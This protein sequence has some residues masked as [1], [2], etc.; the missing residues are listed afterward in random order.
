[1]SST[2]AA[3]FSIFAITATW[4]ADKEFALQQLEA[5]LRA[6]AASQN[7]ELRRT[8]TAAVLGPAPRRSALREHCCFTCSQNSQLLVIPS[9]S[10]RLPRRSL[11]EGGSPRWHRRRT[12]RI[13]RSEV[14][15][16]FSP[17]LSVAT[18]LVGSFVKPL[19]NWGIPA[20]LCMLSY[21]QDRGTKAA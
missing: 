19:M 13:Q 8:K 9:L 11:G 20:I 6:P 18:T 12:R 2:V 17:N 4:A 3:S 15:E 14:Q 5:G 10:N 16:F 1:M 21:S 7:A